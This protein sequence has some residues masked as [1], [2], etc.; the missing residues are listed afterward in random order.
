M[1]ENIPYNYDDEI[2]AAL[3]DEGYTFFELFKS[4]TADTC[5]PYYAIEFKG[6]FSD[7]IPLMTADT[8]FL[9]GGSTSSGPTV[10]V[11]KYREMN[12]NL[13][14]EPIPNDMIFTAEYKPQIVMTIGDGESGYVTSVCMIYDGEACS[15][16]TL[17]T[18]NV[19][20]TS[21]TH[22][23]DS[24]GEDMLELEF[25]TDL[26][27]SKAATTILFAGTYWDITDFSSFP[28]GVKA[29]VGLTDGE[30]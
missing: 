16:E 21:Y 7:S 23:I 4:G 5:K 6:I 20:L 30:K 1:T 25:D 13:L 3:V 9:T 19:D 12:R 26:D 18:Q 22:N 27:I 29:N 2:V 14:W 17:S 11:S 24:I 28:S 8:T 15:Y 10:T